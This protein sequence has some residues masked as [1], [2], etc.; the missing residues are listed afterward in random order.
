MS[1]R[2]VIKIDNSARHSC[3]GGP[4]PRRRERP[5]PRPIV[6]RRDN[7]TPE[8]IER[9]TRERT[10]RVE[11]DRTAR[12][13]R[14]RR[15]EA[16]RAAAVA[17]REG[18]DGPEEGA[19]AA[20]QNNQRLDRNA[21][22]VD[23][24]M[25]ERALEVMA[26]RTAMLRRNNEGANNNARPEV[27]DR[28]DV[29]RSVQPPRNEGTASNNERVVADGEVQPE[30]A[31]AAV[32]PEVDV[33]ESTSVARNQSN[34][35]VASNELPDEV[36]ERDPRFLEFLV[37]S[38]EGFAMGARNPQSRRINAAANNRE[39][40]SA[41]AEGGRAVAARGVEP[42]RNEEVPNGEVGPEGAAVLDPG[43]NRMG[44]NADPRLVEMMAR[45]E[46]REAAYAAQLR[47]RR[48]EDDARTEASRGTAG[49]DIQAEGDANAESSEQGTIQADGPPSV[50]NG[51]ASP[52]N[53]AAN[54]NESSE[55][56][57]N[58]VVVPPRAVELENGINR[59]DNVA[60][61]NNERA[62][63]AGDRLPA[64]GRGEEDFSAA[65]ARA[66]FPHIDDGRR[67][68][69]ARTLRRDEERA[70]AM[71][72]RLDFE[73]AELLWGPRLPARRRLMMARRAIRGGQLDV[74]DV[75]Q[76]II[77][78]DMLAYMEDMDRF[79]PFGFD[80]LARPARPQP[81]RRPSTRPITPIVPRHLKELRELEEAAKIKPFSITDGLELVKPSADFDTQ[82]CFIRR[83]TACVSIFLSCILL[84]Q[85]LTIHMLAHPPALSSTHSRCNSDT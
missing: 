57:N 67:H 63:P 45:F 46:A 19:N 82:R 24:A 4:H 5:M 80:R 7:R 42:P 25:Y 32:V 59:G 50:A 55:Q 40:L 21:R 17:A 27:D 38:G 13:E 16:M 54:V 14:I 41:R 62:E 35:G 34:D 51:E 8:E 49:E 64:N 65:V 71:A 68:V 20:G 43:N 30:G 77:D 52:E 23:M 78:L 75:E 3:A 11:R 9:A 12:M 83:V 73:E 22:L 29:A 44:R 66:A 28:A 39:R 53:A 26:T 60:G 85:F 69:F 84:T 79:E 76:E 47:R 72:R 37:E 2:E 58:R 81:P 10:A 33:E 61:D 15:L 1:A 36:Y 6:A 56:N 70:A 18:N 74:L 48:E 31:E